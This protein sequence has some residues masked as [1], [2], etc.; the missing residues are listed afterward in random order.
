[1]LPTSRRGLDK[2]PPSHSYLL[3]LARRYFVLF[4]AA[5]AVLFFLA[6]VFFRRPLPL[7]E[8]PSPPP[9]EQPE[10]VKSASALLP[11]LYS[12]YHYDLLRLPRHHW[13]QTRPRPDEKFFFVAGHARGMLYG[14]I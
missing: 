7:T 10:E 3:F 2:A 14:S 1:M 5:V 8:P 11:P 9:V 4:L 13:E 12:N 6:R